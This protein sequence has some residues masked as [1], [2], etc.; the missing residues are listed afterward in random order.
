MK[1][2][3]RLLAAALALATLLAGCAGPLVAVG[4]SSSGMEAIEVVPGAM[5]PGAMVVAGPAVVVA[6]VLELLQAAMKSKGAMAMGAMRS[7]MSGVVV[8]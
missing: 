2:A 1:T 3:R 6:P 8:P 4:L 7:F 5:V